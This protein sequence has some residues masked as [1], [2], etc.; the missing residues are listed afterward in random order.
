M[1]NWIPITKSNLYDG[2]IAALIDACDTAALAAGQANRSTGLIQGVVNDI[3]G[4]IA[5]CQRN[6]LDVNVAAIPSRLKDLA[7]RRIIWALKSAVEID[8]TEAEKIDYANDTRD[9]NRIASC[10]DV[11]EQPDNPLNSSTEMQVSSGVTYKAGRRKASSK[12]MDGLI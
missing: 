1:S 8:P 2:K 7:T 6:R 4:K 10:D 12:K 9:L 11:I 3:R 5:S